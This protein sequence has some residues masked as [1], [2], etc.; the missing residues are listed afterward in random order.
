M[1]AERLYTEVKSICLYEE[2][3]HKAPGAQLPLWYL[4]KIKETV[5]W[6]LVYYFNEHQLPFEF[7]L[8]YESDSLSKDFDGY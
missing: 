8:P 2:S 7:I 4:R 1:S 3:Y 5:F 6:N